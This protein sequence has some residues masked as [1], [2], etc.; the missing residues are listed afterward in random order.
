MMGVPVI[1]YEEGDGVVQLDR[2]RTVIL[3]ASQLET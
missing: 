1:V 3:R 2:N